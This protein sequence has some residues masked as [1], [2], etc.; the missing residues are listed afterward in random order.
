MLNSS[1]EYK[2]RGFAG[3]L[4]ENRNGSGLSAWGGEWIFDLEKPF[5]LCQ[6]LQTI[7]TCLSSTLG[8]GM[9]EAIVSSVQNGLEGAECFDL[10]PGLFLRRVCDRKDFPFVG[11]RPYSQ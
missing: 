7:S 4:G 11:F 6:V 2:R 3:R 8:C 10:E 5:F 9:G 1:V